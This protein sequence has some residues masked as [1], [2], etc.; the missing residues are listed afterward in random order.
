MKM[1]DIIII[2]TGPAGYTAAL[3]SA[4]YRLN[5][6]LIGEMPGGMISEAP[7]VCNF[8]SYEN[9]SGMELAM[10]METHV[11]SLNVEIVY[12]TVEET[13]GENNEFIVKAGQGEHKTKKVILATG[14]ERRRLNLDREKELTGK[15][16]SYCATCDAAFYQEK[17]VGVIG[18]GN[19]ALAAALLLARYAEH[20]IVF[21]RKDKFFRPEPI[22][23]L[24]IEQ[25]KKVE[26]VFGVNVTELLGKDKLQGIELDN[27]ETYDLN[28]LF[29]EIGSLPNSE[30]G[31]QLGIDI[32]GE[33]YI[34]TDDFRR[35]NIPGIYAA[36]DV[37]NS[38][39]KQAITAAG[40]GAEAADSAY[41]DIQREKTHRVVKDE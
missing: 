4:R 33:G 14:Q 23:I 18:G 30:L 17:T 41:Q 20:V 31:K 22:R 37:I 38:P 40:Q 36:G 3:Y 39:L 28:G 10:K 19:A 5:T 9:I 29:I 21:Y 25:E 12:D 32:T 11:K 35:T 15:G 24:E 2:G 8:P 27:G 7:D 1:Y 6:L 34:V 26:T 13:H 16:V